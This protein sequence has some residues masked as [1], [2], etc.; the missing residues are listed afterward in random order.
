MDRLDVPSGTDGRQVMAGEFTLKVNGIE[1]LKA[2]LLKLAPELRKGPARRALRKGAEP[3]LQRAVIE[4]P[5]LV[6]DIYRRGVLIR[7]RGTLKRALKIRNSKDVNATGDV[8]VFINYKPLKKS[9]VDQFKAATGRRGSE[10]PDDPFYFRW[11]IF[12]TRRNKRPR[13]ALQNAGKIL[14]SDALPIIT[15][16]LKSYFDKL[17]AKAAK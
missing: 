7:R 15:D 8:G 9:A 11:I 12:S 1:A 17:N 14:V 2:E 10:N 4:T 5:I 16:S 13:P 6:S 3:V